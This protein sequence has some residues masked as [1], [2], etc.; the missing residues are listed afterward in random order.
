MD[1]PEYIVS[2]HRFDIYE[3][4]GCYPFTYNTPVAYPLSELWPLVIGLVSA[5]YACSF[6]APFINDR[7]D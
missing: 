1:D 6:I 2:G 4:L 3:Q 5:V 7:P